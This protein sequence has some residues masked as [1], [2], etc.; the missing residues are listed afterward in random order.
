MSTFFNDVRFAIRQLFKRPAGTVIILV[1]LSLVIGTVS[2]VFGIVQHEHNARMPF[3][4]IVLVLHDTEHKAHQREIAVP[5]TV[6]A[7]W[8]MNIRCTGFGI[9]YRHLNYHRLRF[10]ARSISMVR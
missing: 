5:A 10:S 1:T 9:I 7:E 4:G 8:H 3:P 6:P 2:L